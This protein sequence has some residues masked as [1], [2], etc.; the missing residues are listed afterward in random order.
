MVEPCIL[1][2][3]NNLTWGR[4]GDL[5]YAWKHTFGRREE[6]VQSEMYAGQYIEKELACEI[7]EEKYGCEIER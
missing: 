4:Q 6:E 1:G 3:L 2:R 5:G 7:D